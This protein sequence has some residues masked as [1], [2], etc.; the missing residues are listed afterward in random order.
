MPVTLVYSQLFVD[1]VK[2][3]LQI[4]DDVYDYRLFM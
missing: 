2:Q 1:V 4:V 3:V